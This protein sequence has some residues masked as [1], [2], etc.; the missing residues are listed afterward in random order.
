M[1]CVLSLNY[2]S[3]L[4]SRFVAEKW[5]AEEGRELA[6]GVV[7]CLAGEQTLSIF[8]PPCGALVLQTSIA[9]VVA[10]CACSEC[11]DM[12]PDQAPWRLRCNAAQAK[13]SCLRGLRKFSW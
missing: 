6:A 4:T 7:T 13:P 11:C 1:R 3:L 5:A 12:S 10:F 2:I 8:L 9:F